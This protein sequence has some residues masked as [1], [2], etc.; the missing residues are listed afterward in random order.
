MWARNV[1]EHS[2]SPCC[3]LHVSSRYASGNW[4]VKCQSSP[5]YIVKA[6]PP[7]P[8]P[9]RSLARSPAFSFTR[10]ACSYDVT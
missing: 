2:V 6:Y 4:S 3:Y 10:F 7:H 9:T 1:F 5:R 8:P